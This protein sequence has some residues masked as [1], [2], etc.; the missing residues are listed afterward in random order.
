MRRYDRE[1]RPRAENYGGQDNINCHALFFFFFYDSRLNNARVRF[2]VRPDTRKKL[3][4][5][6]FRVECRRDDTLNHIETHRRLFSSSSR[7]PFSWLF[8]NSPTIR[9]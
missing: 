4:R 3:A 7:Q 6:E 1:L 8:V 2:N 5:Q 9:K